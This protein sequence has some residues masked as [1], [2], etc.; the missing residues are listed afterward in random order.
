MHTLSLLSVW[1]HILAAAI[2]IGG[3][4]FVALVLVPVI[5]RPEHRG[6]APSLVHWTGVRLRWVGW[7]CLAVL[8]GTGVVNLGVRGFGWVDLASGRLWQG[9]FGHTLAMKLVLVAVM[10]LVSVLHD[11]VIG[12]RATAL[13]Q[14]DPGPSGALRLRRLAGWLGR[15]TLLL[16]LVVVGLG[17]I[18]VRGGPW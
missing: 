5:R 8:L 17:V 15:L 14:T 1:L 3:M 12:P 10:L 18:L 9:P 13:W 11:F 16:A 6:L 4:A 7:S 2:W